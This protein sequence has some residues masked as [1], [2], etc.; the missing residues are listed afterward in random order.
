MVSCGNDN[1]GNSQKPSR[2]SAAK[3]KTV[4]AQ[5]KP[6]YKNKFSGIWVIIDHNDNARKQ[7]GVSLDIYHDFLR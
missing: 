1:S 3:S 4:P 6:K 5:V 2:D 7:F